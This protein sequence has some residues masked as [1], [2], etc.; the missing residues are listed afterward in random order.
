MATFHLQLWLA[1]TQIQVKIMFY[2]I[3]NLRM[4]LYSLSRRNV[5]PL[6]SLASTD[7]ISPIYFK[8]SIF[9]HLIWL[10]QDDVVPVH[11]HGSSFSQA[12]SRLSVQFRKFA[13][14]NVRIFFCTKDIV[15][16]SFPFA[17]FLIYAK[18]RLCFS[19]FFL[20]WPNIFGWKRSRTLWQRNINKAVLQK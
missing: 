10:C 2:G 6:S 15:S 5:M 9:D 14:R 8:F 18:G 1:D 3:Y 7:I 20:D 11:R 4:E 12:P 16:L 13:R 17:S 19:A